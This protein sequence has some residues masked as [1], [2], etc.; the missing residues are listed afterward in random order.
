MERKM[1]KEKIGEIR[2]KLI[3]GER[4]IDR[5]KKSIKGRECE[6]MGR[7]R[8]VEKGKKEDFINEVI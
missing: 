4:K 5:L 1:V 7:G 6:R 2:K 8:K 3:G